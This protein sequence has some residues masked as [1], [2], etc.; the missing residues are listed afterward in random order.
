MP[1]RGD[2]QGLTDGDDQA[3]GSDVQQRIVFVLHPNCAVEEV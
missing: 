1:I 2:G 3:E